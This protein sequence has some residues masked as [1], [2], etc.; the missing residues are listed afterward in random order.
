LHTQITDANKKEVQEEVS[1][2]ESTIVY[3]RTE[4]LEEES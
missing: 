4:G 1:S 2:R 3:M